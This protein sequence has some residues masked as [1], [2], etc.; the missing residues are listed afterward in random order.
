MTAQP[1]HEDDPH[2]PEV[3]LRTLPDSEREEFL[4]QYH[5]AARAASNDLANYKQLRHVLSSWSVRAAVLAKVL[6]ER[7]NYFDEVAV[8]GVN[9]WVEFQV[10]DDAGMLTVVDITWVD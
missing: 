3:I 8:L 7:P 9:G 5:D 10:D 2:D 4:R 1:I 6:E